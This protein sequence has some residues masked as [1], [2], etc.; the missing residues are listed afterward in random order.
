MS[1]TPQLEDGHIRVAND[2]YDR[3]LGFGL[4]GQELKVV[5]AIIRKTYGYSKKV[6][7]IAASQISEMCGVSRQH[8]TTTLNALAFRNVITKRPGRLWFDSRHPKGLQEVAHC[9]AF[10]NNYT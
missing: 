2:L 4:S 10:K 6:D 3:I 8:V 9:G 7:D 1:G 5:L